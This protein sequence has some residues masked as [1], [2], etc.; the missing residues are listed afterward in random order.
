MENI[1]NRLQ[2]LDAFFSVCDENATRLRVHFEELMQT[3]SHCLR[4]G[5]SG[6]ASSC[7]AE[8]TALHGKY[9]NGVTHD[10]LKDSH[11]EFVETVSPP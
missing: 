10:S 5:S 9:M 6:K 3:R 4:I 7:R 1:E 11:G 8:A 2:V